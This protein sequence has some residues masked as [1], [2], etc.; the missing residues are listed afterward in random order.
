[1]KDKIMGFIKHPA[2][3]A[4]GVI[5]LVIVIGHHAFGWFGGEKSIPR[6]ASF[7]KNPSEGDEFILTK[8]G[9]Q[10]VYL[11]MQECGDK[12]CCWLPWQFRDSERDG[13]IQT[14]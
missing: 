10:Y 2:V 12:P 1:M 8:N 5:I 3:I 7:P 13:H 9:R 14:V 6:G 11:C 4:I